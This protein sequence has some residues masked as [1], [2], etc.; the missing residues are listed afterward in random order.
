MD[1]TKVVNQL[2]QKYKDVNVVSESE[3][4]SD[5]VST[6]NLTFDLIS[7]GGIPFGVMTE[8]VG[9]SQSGKSLFAQQIL[10]NAQKKYDAVGVIVDRENA[11]TNKR[12]VELGIDTDKMIKVGPQ[13]TPLV[14]DAFNF[15]IDTINLIRKED[16]DTYIVG[17][18]DSIQAF[19]KDV[20]LDKSDSG[21]RAKSI[22]DG[23]RKLFPIIDKKVMLLIANHFYYN[24]G[25]M[26]GDPKRVAGG[27]GLR[28]FNTNR[29]ALEDKLKIMD[30]KKGGE[31][32]GNW[33][34][35]EV[36][37]TRLGPC[38]RTCYIPFFYKEGIPYYGGYIRFLVQ[39]GYLKPKN[40]QEFSK[41]RQQT[42]VYKDKS[43]NEFNAEKLLRD[44][45]ELLF[46]KYPE[47]YQGDEK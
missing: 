20:D 45:P 10:A 7:E 29:F 47:Y 6:G 13:D 21:R 34:G 44:H 33:I 14:V 32:V 37:K 18:I 23:L 40:K 19:D 25:Q 3:D 42:V 9:F 28:Y 35:I 26:F 46:D 8:F 5:F 2:K 43:Y 24:V 39:R 41:F 11:L 1:I 36:Q 4:P 12:A 15:L 30:S 16:G 17:I 27:E 22:K 38:Y 31:V